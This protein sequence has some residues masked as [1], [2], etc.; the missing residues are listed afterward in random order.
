MKPIRYTDI[1][2]ELAQKVTALCGQKGKYPVLIIRKS[3]HP[4]DAHLFLVL[5]ESRRNPDKPDYLVWTYNESSDSM[6][7]GAYDL[8]LGAAFSVMSERVW[9]G[10]EPQPGGTYNAEN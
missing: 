2:M 10:F 5:A 6:N 4:E 8:T 1:T 7:Y 3:N 9:D